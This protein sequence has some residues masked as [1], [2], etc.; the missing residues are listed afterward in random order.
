MAFW[1]ALGANLAPKWRQVGGQVGPKLAPKSRKWRTKGM[2]KKR[3]K[4]MNAVSCK[5]MPVMEGGVP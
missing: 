4:N 3:L 5:I 2:S 1:K